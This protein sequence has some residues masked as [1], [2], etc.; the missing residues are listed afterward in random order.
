MTIVPCTK[1]WENFALANGT[2]VTGRV[3]TDDCKPAFSVREERFFDDTLGTIVPESSSGRSN[4]HT[5]MRTAPGP[6]PNDGSRARD[7]PCGSDGEQKGEYADRFLTFVHDWAI[8]F[9]VT[10]PKAVRC[11]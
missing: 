7:T 5:H 1:C 11:A 8:S 4:V 10:I 3:A 6:W 2:A 9:S